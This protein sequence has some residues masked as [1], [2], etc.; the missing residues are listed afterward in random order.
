MAV[1]YFL[2]IDGVEG[3]SKAE[4]HEKQIGVMSFSWG[5]SQPGTFAQGSG[6]TAGKVSMTDFSFTMASEK[7][8]TGLLKSCATG[9]HLKSAI[10]YCAKSTGKKVEDYMTWTMEPVIVA[11]YQ[12]GGSSGAEVPVD[13]VSLAFGKIKIEYKMQDDKGILK[14]T[15]SFGWDL[16]K[17][18]A[19][20]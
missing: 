9:E 20:K 16:E 1:D 19:I 5:A 17:V 8:M 6:G 12:T 14:P 2:K 10:L 15:G 3:E 18:A 13:S 7:S 11:S 4:G